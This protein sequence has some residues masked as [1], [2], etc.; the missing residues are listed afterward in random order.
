MA[1][2]KYEDVTTRV[3]NERREHADDP[4]V[5]EGDWRDPDRVLHADG[6]TAYSNDLDY[7]ESHSKS[8][9][10][11]E[12][13]GELRNSDNHVVDTWQGEPIKVI[14]QAILEGRVLFGCLVARDLQR[15]G[16]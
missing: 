9:P 15:H 2:A 1:K 7:Q 13:G 6:L 11:W 8:E 4:N 16:R 12:L 14:K 10:N 5:L 3:W